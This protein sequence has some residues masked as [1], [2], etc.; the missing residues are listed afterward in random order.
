MILFDATT[1]LLLL[2]PLTPPPIDP[3]TGQ[4]VVDAQKRI[5]LLVKQLE[6]QKTKIIIPTPA[7]S[8]ILVREG[9]AGS[10]YL[11][12]INSS[13]SFKVVPFDQRAAVEVAAMTYRDIQGGDKR[14]GS[15]DIWAKIKYDRQIVAIGVVEEVTEIYSDD[16]GIRNIAKR[17]QLPIPVTGVSDLP[18]PPSP[19]PQ[20][21]L[22][23]TFLA[24]SRPPIAPNDQQVDQAIEEVK[25]S[26]KV[27]PTS[28]ATINP[29]TAPPS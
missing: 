16:E 29:L 19:P 24:E 18:L 9:R 13:A 17:L 25:D 6:K 20:K 27:A 21:E 23:T 7:L 2:H 11:N 5:N 26:G 8:E 3:K 4:L 15:G 14:G 1:I 22:Q 28:P 12:I 10:Q